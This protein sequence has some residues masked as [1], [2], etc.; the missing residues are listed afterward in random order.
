MSPE[1]DY[2]IYL[3]EQYAAHKERSTGEVMQEWDRLGITDLIYDMYERY[4]VERIENAFEDID[5][6]VTAALQPS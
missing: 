5:E 3:I 4:H 1:M 6:M 2:F